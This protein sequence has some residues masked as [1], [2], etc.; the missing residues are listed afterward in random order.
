MINLKEQLASDLL[1]LFK[2][3]AFIKEPAFFYE[4]LTGS[5]SCV[6]LTS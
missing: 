4:T 1:E 5:I 6:K 2:H 3:I